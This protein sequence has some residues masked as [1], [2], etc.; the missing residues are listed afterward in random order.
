MRASFRAR[1]I[2]GTATAVVLLGVIGGLIH[3]TTTRLIEDNR[4]VAHTYN[5]LMAAERVRSAINEAEMAQRGY[6]ITRQEEFLKASHEAM[7][8]VDRRL[9]HLLLLTADNDAQ[10][11]RLASL[12]SK[13]DAK[14]VLM[15]RAIALRTR[16]GSRTASREAVG[17]EGRLLMD[18]IRRLLEDI[19]GEERRILDRRA[20]ESRASTRY[21]LWAFATLFLMILALFGSIFLLVRRDMTRRSSEEVAIREVRER[22]ELAVRGSRDGIWDWNLLTNVVYFSPRWKRMLGY[23]DDELRGDFEEWL[24]RLHPDDRDPVLATIADYH[25]GN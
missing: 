10:Q 17:G 22:F 19:D 20:G 8:Q 1:I 24:S 21:A 16:G 14:S 2:L 4:W 12:R 3:R 5:S 13:I 18:E 9:R 23:E 15:N 7:D 25:A 6:L 11:R